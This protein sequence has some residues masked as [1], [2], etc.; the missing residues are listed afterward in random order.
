M[1]SD[2]IYKRILERSKANE[3]MLAFLVDPDKAK[4]AH[5]KALCEL[6]E[7]QEV[8]LFL[9]GGSLLTGGDLEATINNLKTYS[10]IPVVIFPGS[11]SQISGAADALLFLSLLS[12]RNAEMLI[13]QQVV[14]APYLYKSDI[15]VISTAYLLIDG[16]KQTTASYISNSTPIPADKSEI[17]AFTALAGQYLGMKQ[18]YLDAGSGATNQVPAK[19]IKAVS[20][21]IDVPLIVG[22]GIDSKEKILEAHQAGADLVVIGNA[23]EKGLKIFD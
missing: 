13:G 16:G 1:K 8:A 2:D 4:D 10:S 20:E 15:E 19:M 9:V 6:A 12:S 3:K 11:P 18:V 21:K 17:A 22:G 7:K 23:L 14:A 5:L